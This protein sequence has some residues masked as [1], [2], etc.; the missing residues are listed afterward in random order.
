MTNYSLEQNNIHH[1]TELISNWNVPALHEIYFW[2]IQSSGFLVCDQSCK[3]VEL[4]CDYNYIKIEKKS[5]DNNF[6]KSQC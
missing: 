3:L 6:Y 1:K 4:K 2:W 5:I